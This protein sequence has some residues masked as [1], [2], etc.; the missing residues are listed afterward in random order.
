MGSLKTLYS[1]PDKFNNIHAYIVLLVDNNFVL[2]I[3][4]ITISTRFARMLS[5]Q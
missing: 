4:K 3:D 2:I 5:H 1:M